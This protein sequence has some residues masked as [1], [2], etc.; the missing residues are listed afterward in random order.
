MQT[1]IYYL[2]G[3][4]NSLAIATLLAEK[5]PGAELRSMTEAYKSGKLELDAE[6]VG[7][8]FPVY[9]FGIPLSF[10]RLLEKAEWGSVRHT[11]AIAN[12]GGM[13]GAA[14]YQV[15]E[16]VEMRGGHL[17]AG[18]LIKMPDNYLPLYNIT[19]ESVQQ[20]QFRVMESQIPVIAAEVAQ[21]QATGIRKS[22]QRFD[23]YIT[24]LI[25][26][27]IYHFKD[28][29]KKFWVTESCNGCG[30]CAFSC[31]FENIRMADGKP[32]WQH[33]CEFCMRCINICPERAIQYKKGTLKKGRYINPNIKTAGLLR[34]AQHLP[35]KQ[36]EE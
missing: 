13:P 11:F 9:V 8:V 28:M 25:Y 36:A 20:E 26:F 6:V 4:G 15:S 22:K 10:R 27:G 7:F 3:T 21:R 32:Q 30:M 14:L 17:D 34:E 23:R 33:K 5:L 31:P 18:Y 29:D 12:F 1:V 35:G 19:T 2:T 16:L 24:P